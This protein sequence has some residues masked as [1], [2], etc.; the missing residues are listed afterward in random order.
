MTMH[1][2]LLRATACAV[3]PLEVVAGEKQ[4][5]NVKELEGN[6]QVSHGDDG[7]TRAARLCSRRQAEISI[8]ANVREMAR[9]AAKPPSPEPQR[10]DRDATGGRTGDRAGS[11]G[12]R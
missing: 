3:F 7:T 10:Q 9:V 1:F 11:P 6:W 12:P 2:A 5:L 8:V 4:I